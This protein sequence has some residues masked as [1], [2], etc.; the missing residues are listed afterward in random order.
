MNVSKRLNSEV[1]QEICKKAGT[2]ILRFQS[3]EIA[4]DRLQQL[5]KNTGQNPA[6]LVLDDVWPGNRTSSL[7]ASFKFKE[8][9]MSNY[10][11]LVTSRIGLKGF[12]VEYQL[13]S[14]K[15]GDAML[16]LRYSARLTGSSLIPEELQRKV[17]FG[18][19]CTTC[20]CLIIYY[21]QKE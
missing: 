10:K 3:E 11:I 4:L 21:S 12:D 13:E 6:L 18:L 17:I 15:D 5:L 8:S 9:E 7:L 1:V 14:L 2:P 19:K 20:T 16:L